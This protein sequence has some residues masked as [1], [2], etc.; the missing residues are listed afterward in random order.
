MTSPRY[1]FQ[2]FDEKTMVKVLGRDLPISHKASYEVAHFIKGRKVAWSLKMLELVA[3]G[4][5]AV[6]YRRY[7]MDVAHKP[8]KIGAA[9]YPKKVSGYVIKLLRNLQ[10]AARSK[11]LDLQKL[12]IIHAAVQKGPIRHRY[13]RKRG[14]E[15]KNTHF[16]LVAKEIETKEKEIKQKK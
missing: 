1:N 11:G 6:P 7:C 5:V 15:R 12:T 4:K 16:E 10:G 9:R 14:L 3:E 13:G 2:G 8:G